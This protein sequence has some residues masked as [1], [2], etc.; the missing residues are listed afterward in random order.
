MWPQFSISGQ[1]LS[2]PQMLEW[3][4]LRAHSPQ[5]CLLLRGGAH[6]QYTPPD[7]WPM[8]RSGSLAS[9]SDNSEKPSQHQGSQPGELRPLWQLHHS[10]TSPLPSAAPLTACQIRWSPTSWFGLRFLDFLTVQKLS[11]FSRTRNSSIHTTLL[12]LT[13]ST[14]FNKLYEILNTLL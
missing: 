14:V 2:F 4:L 11:T 6:P 1:R 7:D 5:R 13:F 3:C 8:Q 10:S 12:F 9:I